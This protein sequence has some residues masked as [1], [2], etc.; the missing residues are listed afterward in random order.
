M[1]IRFNQTGWEQLKPGAYRNSDG[2]IAELHG[3]DI[4]PNLAAPLED[5]DALRRDTVART[6]ASGGGLIEL[7]PVT[8]HG[9]PAFQEIVKLPL[10]DRPGVAYIASFTLPRA[11]RSLVFKFLCVE[12]GVTGMR[13]STA[14][15]RFMAE[16]GKGRTP[17][18]M[19]RYWAQ[20]PY[21]PEVQG[22]LPRNWSEDPWW[23]QHFPQH[24]LSRAR[25]LLQTMAPTIEVHPDFHAAPPWRG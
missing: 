5:L 18:E 3:F 17:D 13:D 11:D 6:A 8:L 14:F 7:D 12:Q 15:D 23:D 4:P 21:A 24:P 1:S 2:D 25:R 16:H 20:H 22:G 10:P 19:M 9:L